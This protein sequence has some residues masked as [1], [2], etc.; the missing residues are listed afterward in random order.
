MSISSH[1]TP[2]NTAADYKTL[3]KDVA[4]SKGKGWFGT[5]GKCLVQDKNGKVVAEEIGFFKAIPHK[6][7]P[8]RAFRWL[9]SVNADV[10]STLIGALEEKDPEKRLGDRKAEVIYSKTA[11]LKNTNDQKLKFL[12]ADKCASMLEKIKKDEERA[13]SKETEKGLNETVDAWKKDFPQTLDNKKT[14]YKNTLLSL[15]TEI[16]KIEDDYNKTLNEAG[17]L[18]TFNEKLENFKEA[19]TELTTVGV[20]DKI[21]TEIPKPEKQIPAITLT[22]EEQTKAGTREKLKTTLESV[23]NGK[24]MYLSWDIKGTWGISAKKPIMLLGFINLNNFIPKQIKHAFQKFSISSGIRNKMVEG[25]KAAGFSEKDAV[26]YAGKPLD[27]VRCQR[28]LSEINAE[29]AHEKRLNDIPNLKKEANSLINNF[30]D[31]KKALEKANNE[32]VLEFTNKK[33][34]LESQLKNLKNEIEIAKKTKILKEENKVKFNESFNKLTE[35]FKTKK[36]T[37]TL[38]SQGNSAN[39]PQDALIKLKKE[40]ETSVGKYNEMFEKNKGLLPQNTSEKFAPIDKK[41]LKSLDTVSTLKNIQAPTNEFQDKEI[42]SLDDATKTITDA[43]DKQTKAL[44]IAYEKELE[45]FKL[46]QSEVEKKLNDLTKAV[47]PEKITEDIELPSFDV[48]SLEKLQKRD[49]AFRKEVDELIK[50]FTDK[51]NFFTNNE[52]KGSP[53]KSLTDLQSDTNEL[54]IKYDVAVKGAKKWKLSEKFDTVSP[55][56][57]PVLETLE[58][59]K[60]PKLQEITECKDAEALK[61]LFRKKTEDLVKAYNNKTQSLNDTKTTVTEKLNKLNEPIKTQKLKEVEAQKQKKIEAEERRKRLE[62]K[63]WLAK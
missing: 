17:K 33:T 35:E 41:S 7:F 32:K 27:S 45:T 20:F 29:N 55:I 15:Q 26:K 34:T 5:S 9:V 23:I 2:T 28:L 8:K 40:I 12:D 10:I 13:Q 30:E 48:G 60:A 46:E 52:I 19:K 56:S 38:S 57:T 1:P 50:A 44:E 16:N 53:A 47:N 4:D 62:D 42:S 49:D 51:K 59:V 25:F 6:M 43:F 18:T 14:D 58:A 54:I 36:E 63:I 3:L 21:T 39:N 31:A 11:L 61:E 22:K 37:Y 24:D